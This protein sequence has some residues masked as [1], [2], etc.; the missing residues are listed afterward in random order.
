MC[1]GYWEKFDALPSSSTTEP[2]RGPDFV[3]T[4]FPEE[5]TPPVC[6]VVLWC[7]YL[8]KKKKKKRKIRLMGLFST[9]WLEIPTYCRA[10]CVDFSG[11]YRLRTE[12]GL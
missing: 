3:V 12:T 4:W 10:M 9:T 6:I 2:A 11:R 8:Q 1:P 5:L 7:G